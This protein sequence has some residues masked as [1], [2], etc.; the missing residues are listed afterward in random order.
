MESTRGEPKRGGRGLSSERKTTQPKQHLS[1]NDLQSTPQTRSTRE[2]PPWQPSTLHWLGMPNRFTPYSI[3]LIWMAGPDRFDLKC[4]F[5][6]ICRTEGRGSGRGWPPTSFWPPKKPTGPG[7]KYPAGSLPTPLPAPACAS[8]VN[9]ELPPPASVDHVHAHAH[10][11]R[12][13]ITPPSPLCT[14]GCLGMKAC[15]LCRG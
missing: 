10:H 3:R 9:F 14:C 15:L 6:T 5:N 11:P 12:S 8:Q 7:S 1:V 13:A 4:S 2:E